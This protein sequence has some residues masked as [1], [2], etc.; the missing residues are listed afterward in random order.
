MKISVCMITNNEEPRIATAI[1]STVGLADEV[2]VVDSGSTDDTVH[3]ARC[4]GAHVIEAGNSDNLSDNRNTGLDA[5][6]GDWTV[7]LDAD[8]TIANPTGLRAFLESDKVE[9]IHGV[10]IKL[11]YLN[12]APDRPFVLGPKDQ[13]PCPWATPG[14]WAQGP[15]AGQGQYQYFHGADDKPKF[16][17]YPLRIWRHGHFYY[18]YR[19]HEKP[20]RTD[21]TAPA[22]GAI[23]QF[24]FE[25]RR[26]SKPGRSKQLLDWLKLD[27]QDYPDDPR[28]LYYLARQYFYHEQPKKAIETFDRYFQGPDEENLANAYYFLA[29]AYAK[30]G[31]Q[32]AQIRAL[33]QMC[34]AQPARRQ[35]WGDLATLYYDTGNHQLAAS[36]IELL[37]EIPMPMN[38]YAVHEWYG[39]LPH[40][41]LAQC[42]EKMLR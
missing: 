19:A 39:E 36:L 42:R 41:I 8:E 12:T 9:G 10:A 30:L 23:T 28:V 16:Y 13:G 4:A 35:P 21:P 20:T 7:T 2:I 1:E 37:L 29:R 18:R 5:A 38:T 34:A 26:P 17:L 33:H 15:R 31:N 27:L 40:Q 6:K 32:P 3:V 22:V 24:V 14:P 11:L 25:H